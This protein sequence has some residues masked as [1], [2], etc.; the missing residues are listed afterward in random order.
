[1]IL[2]NKVHIMATQGMITLT[3]NGQVVLKVVVG[4]NGGEVKKASDAIRELHPSKINDLELIYDSMIESE[5]GC[6][7]CLVVANGNR[8]FSKGEDPDVLE[9][10]LYRKKFTE[11]EFNPRWV[12]GQCECF[13]QIELNE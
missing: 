7:N 6:E 3:R 11:P 5:F 8:I 12:S 13:V 9:K 1:M 2:N 10:G 4:C